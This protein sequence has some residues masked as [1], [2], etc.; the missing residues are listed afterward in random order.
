MRLLLAFMAGSRGEA[1]T[2]VGKGTE[3]SVAKRE[4]ESPAST[5]Q[6]MEEVCQRKNLEA[7]LKRVTAREGLLCRF[8]WAIPDSNQ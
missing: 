1:P 2:A 7:A 3:P 6:L 4:T 8:Q 5:E